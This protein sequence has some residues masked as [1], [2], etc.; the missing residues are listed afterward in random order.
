MTANRALAAALAL[1]GLAGL[2]A[3]GQARGPQEA[4]SLHVPAFAD[5]LPE[6]EV[7]YFMLPDRF[8]NGDPSNDT[9]GIPGDRLAHGFDPTDWGFYHGGDLKGLTERLDYL[10]AL[11]VTA[12]WVGPIFRNMPVQGGPDN[13]SSGYHGYWIT[14]FLDVDPH[15]GT[16]EEFKAFVEAAHGR[17]LKVYMDI[18]TNHTADV[19]QY[20]ECHRPG[21]PVGPTCPYRP[22]V[23]YP[24]T[25]QGGVDGPPINA[26]FLGDEP[27]HL[28]AENYARLTDPQ[29]AYTP[30]IP[31]GQEAVKNPAWLNDPIYY[32]NRG[33]TTFEGE[34]GLHGDFV[35]LDDINTEHPRVVEG[36]IDI[37]KS[38]I[39]DFKVDGFRIDTIKHVRPE[40]WRAWAPEIMAHA[41]AQGI[42]HFHMF[43]EAYDYNPIGL[44]R[45]TTES[46][47]PTVIDFAFQGAVRDL[48]TGKAGTGALAYVFDAD[49][50]YAGG[51]DTARRL[52][53]F[54]GNHDM[55]RLSLFL[56]QASP[57]MPEAEMLARVRL[58]HAMMMFLRGVPVIYSGDEQGFV[59]DTNDKGTRETLFASQVAS[60]NDNDLLGTDR[61]TA[62]DNFET[63]HPLFQAIAGMVA[64]R[65][66]EPA[67]R[68]GEQ[69]VRHSEDDG[70]L[71]VVSRVLGGTEM[72]VAF[73]AETTPRQARVRVDGAS[74]T[75]EALAGTCSPTPVAPGVYDVSVPALDFVI[76]RAGG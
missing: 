28:T 9:G 26:G 43:G 76:C 21:A 68:R 33:N 54:L 2:G 15:L 4:P 58:G 18:I 24:F 48:L 57:N 46:G 40:F 19:I 39:T 42:P 12:V 22:I 63:T 16:R 29:W 1:L 34:N 49:A 53:T 47:M 45:L 31:P 35:G 70:G 14:D 55:G 52:P 17:G 67:L 62:V 72:V 32:S 44:A 38:W 5:R 75:F 59:P 25:R 10:Q 7:I 50:I 23:E 11:G 64:L 69:V 60:Y 20:E 27:R 74:A 65:Q 66:S 6:D 73:N 3:C 71:L 36:F 56:R 37:Y 61:T 51:R 8:A 41:A 13:P 30:Y